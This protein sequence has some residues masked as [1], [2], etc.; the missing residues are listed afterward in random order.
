MSSFCL[1]NSNKTNVRFHHIHFEEMTMV[2]NSNN[3]TCLKLS[4]HLQKYRA[5]SSLAMIFPS[6]RILSRTSTKWG[7]LKIKIH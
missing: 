2:D 7:E 1:K 5:K 3:F 4:Q 6:M